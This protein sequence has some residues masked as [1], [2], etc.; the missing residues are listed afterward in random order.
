MVVVLPKCSF[1]A[2]VLVYTAYLCFFT[3]GTLSLDDLSTFKVRESD[4]W[5]V[6]L[7]EYKMYFPP[8]PAGGA[9]LSF[10]LKLMHGRV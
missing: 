2:G 10:I 1:L 7:G 9:I 6:Q 5:T 4:A 3:D 8:P